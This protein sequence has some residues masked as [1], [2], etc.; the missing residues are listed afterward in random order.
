MFLETT[1]TKFSLSVCFHKQPAERM[2]VKKIAC[3]WYR[4]PGAQ[5]NSGKPLWLVYELFEPRSEDCSAVD[6]EL[7]RVN[8]LFLHGSGMNRTVWEYYV[9]RLFINNDSFTLGKIVTLDMVN[10]GDSG[11]LNRHNLG[12]NFNW[13]DGARDAC[14]VGFKEFKFNTDKEINVVIGH[15]MGGFQAICCNILYP[16]LFDLV[17]AI[18]PVIISHDMPR[19]PTDHTVVP[20]KF[21]QLL[22]SKMKDQF[23]NKTEYVEYMRTNSFY[24]DAHPDILKT[25]IEFEQLEE[26]DS[27]G[28]AV[29]RT[30]MDKRQ[31]SIC[32]L[33]LNPSAQWLIANLQFL[34]TPVYCIVGGVSTWTPKANTE[35]MKEKIVNLQLDSVAQAGHLVNLEHP[36]ECVALINAK[37]QHFT[38]AFCVDAFVARGSR[39]RDENDWD[40][41]FQEEYARMLHTRVV[42]PVGARRWKL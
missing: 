24:K 39:C 32:Y 26:T 42:S 3:E 19:G 35:I 6:A 27:R 9:S 11:V 14:M 15:S 41:F 4:S 21:F 18:E 30:K 1:K 7:I 13:I 38:R 25:L 23:K 5:L 12:V 37:L 40:A 31:N 33:T 20:R 16:N 29:I 2:V 36:D 8:L 10:H 28:N 22:L 17:I 34:T